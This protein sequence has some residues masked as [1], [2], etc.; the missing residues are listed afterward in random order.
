MW[1]TDGKV[2]HNLSRNTAGM[3]NTAIRLNCGDHARPKPARQSSPE[4]LLRLCMLLFLGS[5]VG[6]G[7]FGMER[8][9][10]G[11]GE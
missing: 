7:D 2:L 10:V 6:G 9:V 4:P 11:N 5:G 1:N 3:E 8:T